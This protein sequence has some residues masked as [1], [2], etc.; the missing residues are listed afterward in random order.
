LPIRAGVF[1]G[2]AQGVATK[3]LAHRADIAQ[4]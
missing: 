2:D 1:D 4:E 3:V